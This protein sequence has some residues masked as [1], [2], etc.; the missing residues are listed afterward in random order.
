VNTRH[1]DALRS[2]AGSST[3]INSE[4]EAEGERSNAVSNK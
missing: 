1:D 4:S 2:T 3:P